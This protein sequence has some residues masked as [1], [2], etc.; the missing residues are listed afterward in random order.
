MFVW[1]SFQN[2]NRIIFWESIPNVLACQLLSQFDTF[3][4]TIKHN[5]YLIRKE[6]INFSFI[7]R[8]FAEFG[9]LSTYFKYSDLSSGK[10]NISIRDIDRLNGWLKSADMLY[11]N[12]N[13]EE[14]VEGDHLFL[15]LSGWTKMHSSSWMS[16][17]C[18]WSFWQIFGMGVLNVFKNLTGCP[19]FL[20][21]IFTCKVNF[22][23]LD[24]VETCSGPL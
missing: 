11:N 20:C 4:I 21:N 19:L 2:K 3:R 22:R 24:F 12:S 8:L 15:D 5:T 23:N 9:R 17:G 16:V 6:D 13:K 18:P 14:V 7:L 1:L 10:F